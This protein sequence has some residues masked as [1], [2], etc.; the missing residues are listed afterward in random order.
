MNHC[1]ICPHECG[2]D[3][4]SFNLGYC[5]TNSGFSISSIVIHRGEEPVISGKKGICNIFF[6]GCNLKC[7]YCQN[8]QIS[9][10]NSTKNPM[11]LSEIV[12]KIAQIMDCGI[13]I[14]GFVS[15]SHVVNQ[16]IA[17]VEELHRVG[18]YP[19][20]VYNTNAYEKVETIKKLEGIVDVYLPDFKYISPI[21]SK[22]YSGAADYFE[23][24]SK[25]IIE[26]YRQK[27]S[28]LFTNDEGQAESGLLIRHLV[29]PGHIDESIL[30]LNYIAREIST[31][32]HLSLMSQYFP[33]DKAIGHLKLGRSLYKEEYQVVVDKM[34]KLGFRN[35][36][37]QELESNKHYRPDFYKNQPFI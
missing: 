34:H 15:S 6:T 31:G 33:A 20:I 37:V 22:S 25:A 19:A 23:H 35:G 28:T 2:N 5:G 30:L 7:I 8:H 12:E 18:L 14:V 4:N 29:L 36:W 11:H 13:N 27:G 24:A 1:T 9:R 10:A 26:M 3:R 16:V 32:V 17:I 21:L